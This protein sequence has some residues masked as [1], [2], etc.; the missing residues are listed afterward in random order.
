[1]VYLVA[2]SYLLRYAVLFDMIVQNNQSCEYDNREDE[3]GMQS[4]TF[5]EK[6]ARLR[7]EK[8]MTQAQLA[9]IMHVTDKAV[10]KW[11]CDVAYPDITSL[12][13]LAESLGVSVDQLLSKT[14][15]ARK[16][17]N[18]KKWIGI[19]LSALVVL[20]SLFQFLTNRL[21]HGDWTIDCIHLILLGGVVWSYQKRVW[22]NSTMDFAYKVFV[23]FAGIALIVWALLAGQG[24]DTYILMG[25]SISLFGA[26]LLC[27]P[28]DNSQR[29]KPEK[30]DD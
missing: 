28:E 22:S 7:R 3:N 17:F 27:L 15:E 1:M 11:E 6:I 26:R 25:T 2:E 23:I 20:F 30:N 5:G 8:Q 9:V 21:I 18:L 29:Q 10:S 16:P 13:L 4:E 14:T 24:G 19:L 12:P